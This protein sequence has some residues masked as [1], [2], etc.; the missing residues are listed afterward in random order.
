MLLAFQ[1]YLG[2]PFNDTCLLETGKLRAGYAP[3]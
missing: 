2:F 1:I 3:V